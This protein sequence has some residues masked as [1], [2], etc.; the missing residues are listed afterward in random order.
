[1]DQFNIDGGCLEI[2]KGCC[3]PCS[4]FQQFVFL[5]DMRKRRLLTRSVNNRSDAFS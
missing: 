4:L 2:S 3:Y 5:E 1:M